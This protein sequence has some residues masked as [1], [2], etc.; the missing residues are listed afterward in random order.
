M[1]DRHARQKLLLAAVN[2]PFGMIGGAILFGLTTEWTIFGVALGALVGGMVMAANGYGLISG[3]VIFG[4][5]TGVVFVLLARAV[6]YD[7]PNLYFHLPLGFFLGW[8]IAVVWMTI[9]K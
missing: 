4:L 3:E 1:G 7:G 5:I 8:I 2:G 6:D 9:T